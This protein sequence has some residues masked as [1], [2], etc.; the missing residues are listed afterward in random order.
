MRSWGIVMPRHWS[1]C[2]FFALVGAVR[3]S[4]AQYPYLVKD[5]WP[6]SSGSIPNN[7]VAMNGLLFF[8]A[9]DGVA[10]TELWKSDGTT[11]GT[12]LVRDVNPGPSGS[13]PNRLTN[14]NGVLYFSANDGVNGTEL[15]KS[16]GTAAGTTMVEDIT[17]GPSGS[18]FDAFAAFGNLLFFAVNLSPDGEEP[19]ISDGTAAGTLLLRDVCPG[20]CSGLPKDPIVVGPTLYF[21]ASHQASLWRTDGTPGGTVMVKSISG[22]SAAPSYLTEMG[23]NIY[24]QAFGVGGFE[25]Y[26]SDGTTAGTM[27]LKDLYPGSSYGFPTNLTNMNGT[28]YFA[29]TDGVN[30]D[31]LWKSDGTTSGTVMAKDLKPGPGS[32]GPERLTVVKDRLFFVADDGVVGD[33]LWQSDG[34]AAGTFVRDVRA[35]SFGSSISSLLAV[36]DT[37]LFTG[38]GRLGVEAYRTGPTMTTPPYRFVEDIARGGIGF[39]AATRLFRV[40]PFAFFAAGDTT[41][42]GLELWALRLDGLHYF[43]VTATDSRNELEWINPIAGNLTIRFRTDTYPVD[44]TDGTF[45]VT[46]SG[47][48]DAHES[49]LH[50]GLTNGTTYYYRAFVDDGAAVV[51]DRK[52][53]GRPESNVNGVEWIYNTGAVSTEPPGLAPLMVL[54]NDWTLHSIAPG[55]DGGTWPPNW[56]PFRTKALAQGRPPLLPVSLGPASRIVLFSS[57]EGVVY[58]L[59]A[60]TGEYLWRSPNLGMLQAAPAAMFVSFGGTDDLVLV[61]TR[62]SSDNTFRGLFP[63]NGDV[64]WTFDNGGVGIGAISSQASVDYALDL[65]YFASRI[66]PS[67]SND[68]LWCLSPFS[69]TLVWSRGL[70]DPTPVGESDGSPTVRGSRLYIGTNDS[71]VHALDTAS[72]ADLWSAPFVLDDGGAGL[73]GAVKGFVWAPRDGNELYLSTNDT[74]WA[75]SD[76]GASAS[77]IWRTTAI[78]KPSVPLHIWHYLY[79][80]GEDGRLYEIDLDV[81]PSSLRSIPLG[82]GSA[83]TGAPS[84]DVS[85]LLIYVGSENGAIYGVRSPLP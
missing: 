23:G 76:D 60:A 16:D 63:T 28:L 44:E 11:A 19:W 52:A 5:I 31:E 55:V 50:S 12:V 67:G 73:D 30:G 71:R 47:P 75:L 7:F 24:F 78:P 61:G 69:G 29:A 37:L 13:F 6:G 68:T 84:F 14:C 34:T 41:L 53:K 77:E 39:S 27:L 15:W 59:D 56:R 40:G 35:G 57:N 43:S 33:E 36:N 22:A 82:D 3:S 58:A 66:D 25:L 70:N 18:S 80:G 10:G 2:L 49:F 54:S 46:A 20:S 65:I 51:S 21:G 26:K 74:V 4:D 9:D 42:T 85:R 8:T 62:E 38:D 81:G 79:V 17:P 32:S 48:T 72:G 83:R 45:L 1:L 64:S